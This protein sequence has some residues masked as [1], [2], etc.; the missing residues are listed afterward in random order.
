[1]V[2]DRT[3]DSLALCPDSDGKMKVIQKEG[4]YQV[5]TNFNV[6]RRQYDGY[7]CWRYINAPEMLTKIEREDDLTVEYFVE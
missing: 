1:L 2:A 4:V 7:L 6:L 5:I 3:G